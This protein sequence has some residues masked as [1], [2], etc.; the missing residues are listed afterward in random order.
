MDPDSDGTHLANVQARSISIDEL[1]LW[2]PIPQGRVNWRV[3]NQMLTWP[4]EAPAGWPRAS[5]GCQSL[6]HYQL[7]SLSVSSKSQPSPSPPR[8][9]GWEKERRG[10]GKGAAQEAEDKSP[11]R[12]EAGSGDSRGRA[13]KQ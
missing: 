2:N 13:G 12:A 7:L 9:A 11:N 10:V 8:P 3:N 6:R 4:R 5:A 1:S